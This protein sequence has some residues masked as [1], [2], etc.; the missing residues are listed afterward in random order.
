[1]DPN[2][3]KLLIAILI[4]STLSGLIS[5]VI[6]GFPLM[7]WIAIPQIVILYIARNIWFSDK[8]N[9][10][11]QASVL[12]IVGVIVTATNSWSK[13]LVQHF[14]SSY[15][16]TIPFPDETI[17]VVSVVLSLGLVFIVFY[18]TQKHESVSKPEKSINDLIEGPT[19]KEKWANVCDNLSTLIRDIDQNT[20]WCNEY[21]T[22]LEAEVE[23]ETKK[24][25]RK[26]VKDLL[27]AIKDSNDRLFL[28]IGDPGSGKS[29][30]MRK[31]CLDI[32]ST[33]KRDEY[34]PIYVNLKEWVSSK[35][36]T[37]E[38]PDWADLEEFVKKS[39]T[40]KNRY[41]GDFF[42]KYYDILDENGN[43]FFVL[44]SFDEIPQVLGS[45]ADSQLVEDLSKVCREFLLGAKK[46]ASKGILASREYRMPRA[47]FFRATTTLRIRP[48]TLDKIEQ[49]LMQSGRI[50]K[51]TVEQLFR[52]Q[53]GL[54]PSLRNP[55]ISSLLKNY[56]ETNGNALPQGQSEL[57][58][59]Y[60]ASSISTA[61]KR[62]GY[63]HITFYEIE[64]VTIQIAKFIFDESG[65][66][67]PLSRI[68][69]T[70]KNENLDQIVDMLRY[71]RIAR[72]GG[73]Q[74]NEFSFSHRRF[75]E[76]FIVQGLLREGKSDLP[77]DSIPTDSKWRDT[78][79]LYCE[80]A[81]FEDAQKI[82]NFCWYE[83]I[84]P[85]SNVKDKHSRHCLRFLN[86]AFRGRKECL[87]DFE[88]DLAQYLNTAITNDSYL[89]DVKFAAEI[90]GV[91]QDEDLDIVATSALLYNN[92]WINQTT[93]RSCRHLSSISKDL[94]MD[95]ASK[96][97]G[98][99]LPFDFDSDFGKNFEMPLKELL[100]SLSLSEAFS[101]LRKRIEWN[102]FVKKV[103]Y[104]SLFGSFVIGGL[105][106]LFMRYK[107]SDL[108]LGVIFV[109]SFYA[110]LFI[111][112]QMSI[113]VVLRT[114]FK[115]L[116]AEK[117]GLKSWNLFTI[118]R[119]L[120]HKT[121]GI[122]LIIFV[123]FMTL[124]AWG[125]FEEIVLPVLI[126]VMVI[127]MC[128]FSVFALLL[129][130]YISK[131][132]IINLKYY[133]QLEISKKRSFSREEVY[134]HY[135]FLARSIFLRFANRF[136]LHLE[137]N[138]K[139]VHGEWPDEN[140]LKVSRGE[141]KTRL[142]KLDEKWREAEERERSRQSEN[143]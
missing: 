143:Y 11:L 50:Q 111:L 141:L 42:E 10:L 47:E 46:R 51:S 98:K 99:L 8:S 30:A 122:I 135:R 54:I 125:E 38:E 84:E 97:D 140:F 128:F 33:S 57:F 136:V 20:N 64:S 26:L 112:H 133:S 89:P 60:I 139:Q 5:W 13:S 85:A 58:E 121:R 28:L 100:I 107:Y 110:S 88:K 91:L 43:L 94:E 44:D 90:I 1:M 126:F 19:I 71:T 69:A 52:K 70:I 103:E 92:S 41:L 118:F 108:E 39:L 123:I 79:V 87:V 24:G 56:L 124:V 95:L 68:R 77:I 25:T 81:P 18:F 74:V 119:K 93:L 53:P 32:L 120:G 23:V 132:Y 82:A 105:I 102:L 48:F 114:K 40:N 35:D 106:T 61:Q 129:I 131:S 3:S 83:V 45:T 78:L 59:N 55:F 16:I 127:F 117:A 138:V 49:S 12:A 37:K 86:D 113:E 62:K 4:I 101:G 72:G 9:Y 134:I 7:L 21:Y 104:I 80:V 31:L 137:N 130:Y 76:Y 75:Y 6:G 96:L 36:W 15:G 109:P 67:A 63:E 34:I 73:D 66:Q 2:K 65:L 22:P 17:S 14:L 116:I 27:S 29:V 115:D 142:S